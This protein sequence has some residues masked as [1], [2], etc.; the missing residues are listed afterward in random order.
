MNFITVSFSS[1]DIDVTWMISN[2]L[3]LNLTN[4]EVLCCAT[5]CRQHQL[6]MM[7]V[8]ID[9]VPIT[10]VVSVTRYI[11][12]WQPFPVDTDSANGFELFCYSVPTT[13]HSLV[14]TCG[15]I[16]DAGSC[17]NIFP[18]GLRQWHT[19]TKTMVCWLVLHCT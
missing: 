12:H 2:R 9:S 10:P 18:P 11:C 1:A 14:G 15:H 17:F 5:S 7:A 19:W 16:P 4:T 6:P 8:L 13:S 3:Q